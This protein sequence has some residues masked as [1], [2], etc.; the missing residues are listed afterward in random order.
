MLINKR[1]LFSQLKIGKTYYEYY[2][3]SRD[4]FMGFDGYIAIF[5]ENIFFAYKKCKFYELIPFKD[6]VEI[7]KSSLCTHSDSINDS[8]LDVK[9]LHMSESDRQFFLE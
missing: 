2:T 1:I 6:I 5:E 4:K 7:Y 8:V 3:D 9:T